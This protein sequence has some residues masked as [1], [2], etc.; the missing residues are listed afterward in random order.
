MKADTPPLDETDE[1]ATPPPAVPIEDP[2]PETDL[3]EVEL[4]LL[5][6]HGLV[7][8]V[9]TAPAIAAA[10]R[11]KGVVRHLEATYFDTEDHAL[12]AAGYTLRV[13]RTGKTHHITVK[14][15]KAEADTPLARREWEM[16]APSAEPDL[17]IFGEALPEAVTEAAGRGP[18]RPLYTTAVRRH[19]VLLDFQ[20]ATVELAADSGTI[21]ADGRHERV[22]EIEL[23]LKSGETAALYRLALGLADSGRVDPSP[24]S[25]SARGQDLMRNL[26][27][28]YTKAVKL[29]LSSSATLDETI[30][31]IM[32]AALA[33][34]LQNKA[35]AYDG[36]HPEGVHQVRVALRRLRALLKLLAK[37]THSHELERLREE[38]K[39]LAKSLDDARNWDVF[40]TETLPPVDEATGLPGFPALREAA[41]AMRAEAYETVRAALDDPRSGRFQLELALWIEERGWRKAVDA[42][43]LAQLS[44]RARD[45]AD[46][47]LSHLQ[48]KVVRRGKGF[49][50]LSTEERHQVR[51]AMKSLRY[52]ADFFLPL[53]GSGKKITA[54]R[55]FLSRFQD[56]LGHLN[57][58]T[59]TTALVE[60]LE[61][62]H[63]ADAFAKPLGAILGF[64]AYRAAAGEA[65]LVDAWRAFKD[66]GRI[67]SA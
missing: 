38:A 49:A 61:A 50:H 46:T 7:T 40:L 56:R 13:R 18:L 63:G 5:A 58:I 21:S 23:E 35:A 8:S 34:L 31:A 16:V 28:A 60:A 66:A 26:A 65:E 55:K 3:V 17:S 32:R 15:S 52:A 6:D 36:R 67:W 64:Q 1:A 2:A 48:T 9:L 25:K 33:H 10:A 37:H 43:G 39:W 62:R 41:E 22:D 54:Y 47:A 45:F 14:A 4:K 57:D 44:G 53:F 12:E 42:T 20:S 29:H 30:E 19:T 11:N 27:P 51:L 24:R 59:T